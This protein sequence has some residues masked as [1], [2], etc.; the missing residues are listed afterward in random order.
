M[1]V[2]ERHLVYGGSSDDK[3]GG[4]SPEAAGAVAACRWRIG[5]SCAS[6]QAAQ[7]H[8]GLLNGEARRWESL[9]R[10]ACG[11]DSDEMSISV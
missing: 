1:A 3:V 9:A 7:T 10:Y 2:E 5:Y 8:H 6:R 11:G 4:G